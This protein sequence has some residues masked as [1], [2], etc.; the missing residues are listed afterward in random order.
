MCDWDKH[1]GDGRL[2]QPLDGKQTAPPAWD[3]HKVLVSP[4]IPAKA[5]LLGTLTGLTLL[6]GVNLH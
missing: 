1:I 4:N 2:C 6:G 3:E 5:L